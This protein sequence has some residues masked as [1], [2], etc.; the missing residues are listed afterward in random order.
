M[1]APSEHPVESA[2]EAAPASQL[3]ELSPRLRRVIADNGGPFTFTGTCSY[4]VGRGVVAILDPGPAGKEAHLAALLDAVRDEKVSHIVVTHTHRDHSPAARAL[5]KATGAPIVGC[6]PHRPARP[7][8]ADSKDRL[9][10][11]GDRDHV[12]DLLMREGAT[13]SG[14]GWTLSAIATPGHTAN[15]LAFTLKEEN[16]LLSGDHVMAW[17]TT[18]IAPPDGSMADYMASLAHLLTFDHV[19][20]WPG[21]GGPV[22]EPA[23]YVRG[24]AAHRRR[25]ERMIL[26]AVKNGAQNIDAIL[27]AAYPAIAPAL[28]GA[29]SL[30]TLA[31]LEWLVDRGEVTSQSGR[32][33][34]DARY[35]PA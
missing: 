18:I 23:R 2:P 28:A 33:T 7:D 27:E 11:G 35:R 34:F 21:H 30:S 8:A 14:P 5:K 3:T 10:S 15:H 20:Y 19:V 1:S 24:L 4:I 29:A 22:R 26:D 32:A 9:D 25:R 13:I 17:S 31:H 12:P 16:A 6:G